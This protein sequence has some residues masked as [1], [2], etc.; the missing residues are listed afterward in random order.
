[1]W[2]KVCCPYFVTASWH[3]PSGVYL[4]RGANTEP[5][6]VLFRLTLHTHNGIYVHTHK[7]W[8]RPSQEP[9]ATS[10]RADLSQ[11]ESRQLVK[12]GDHTQQ[13]EPMVGLGT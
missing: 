7:W 9:V 13:W 5:S 11:A 10:S 4:A 2:L 1:M 8:S 12:E 6:I 3:C